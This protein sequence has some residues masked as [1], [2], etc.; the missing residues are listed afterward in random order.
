[1]VSRL[2]DAAAHKAAADELS[3]RLAKVAP[4]VPL[5]SLSL[6]ETQASSRTKS[7]HSSGWKLPLPPDYTGV[8]RELIIVLP[9]DFPAEVM[10]AYVEPSPF[11]VW[12]HCDR[13]GKLC[14][15]MEDNILVGAK[16]EAVVADFIDKLR[17]L[18]SLVLAPDADANERA[19]EFNEEWLAYWMPPLNK[20][21]NNVAAAVTLITPPPGG[22]CPLY[23]CTFNVLADK[24]PRKTPPTIKLLADSE[25]ALRRWSANLPGNKLTPPRAAGYFVPLKSVPPVGSPTS[26]DDVQTLLSV[27]E[28]GTW[29]KVNHYLAAAPFKDQW[30]VFSIPNGAGAA[31]AAVNFSPSKRHRSFPGAEHYASDKEV[32]AKG[33]RDEK[34][35]TWIPAACDVHRADMAWMRDRDQN[36][37][38]K[39]AAEAV[40]SIVGDGA[41]GSMI[42]KGLAHEGVGNLGTIDGDKLE[43]ENLGRHELGAEDLGRMKAKAHADRLAAAFPHIRVQAIPKYIQ[44]LTDD[45]MDSLR[46]STLVICATANWPADNYLIKMRARGM[47]G[48]PLLICWSE[49][50][51]VAGHS[52]LSLDAKDDL[53]SQFEGNGDYKKRVT[54]WPAGDVIRA[55][56][57]CQVTFQP[58]GYLRLNNT[59][60]M[61]AAHALEYLLGGITASERRFYCECAQRVRALGGDVTK[62]HREGGGLSSVYSDGF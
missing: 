54:T 20:E 19:R 53:D 59:G 46:K 14:I 4:G 12:P 33:K 40:V 29:K 52:L 57:A 58:A 9:G 8:A 36:K 2:F 38:L 17:W 28:P 39:R 16:P 61:V 50:H 23:A 22:L 44:D 25:E 37:Q 21:K 56:P 26:L 7:E 6:S 49:P 35:L 60:T 1:M 47:L 24:D 48:M 10:Q 18:F 45:E 27:A 11:L 42:A 30:L 34:S 55:L 13:Q 5:Q 3:A 62:Y 31:M 41:L 15:W 43:A 51:G 32:R